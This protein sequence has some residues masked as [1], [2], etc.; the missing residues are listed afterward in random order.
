MGGMVSVGHP[1]CVTS[2][3][4]GLEQH[5]LKLCQN[6]KDQY[7]SIISIA[8]YKYNLST[9]C[10]CYSWPNLSKI[11]VLVLQEFVAMCLLLISK[12]RGYYLNFCGLLR[13]PKLYLETL[14]SSSQDY[15]QASH[16]SLSFEPNLV[17]ETLFWKK[18]W[19]MEK[20]ESFL[21]LTYHK[22]DHVSLDAAESFSFSIFLWRNIEFFSQ[23][24]FQFFDYFFSFLLQICWNTNVPT[25]LVCTE[26]N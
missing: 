4:K 12:H 25:Y 3:L 24:Y 20:C 8:A 9:M 14:F 17:F 26:P 2:S 11:D 5:L 1:T 23:S 16:P 22:T 13:K 7:L 15:M 19:N 10:S 18:M 21:L 6:K